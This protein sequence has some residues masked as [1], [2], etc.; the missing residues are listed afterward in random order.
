MVVMSFFSIFNWLDKIT[1]SKV[2]SVIYF[3]GIKSK[4]K[5]IGG[6]NELSSFRGN[7]KFLIKQ[8]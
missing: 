5:F 1:V 7:D 2:V 3:F 4:L 8:T 6:R